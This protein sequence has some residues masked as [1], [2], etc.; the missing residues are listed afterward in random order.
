MDSPFFQLGDQNNGDVKLQ[1]ICFDGH[2]YGGN[3]IYLHSQVLKKSSYF[4][5]RLSERWSPESSF[6]AEIIITLPPDGS[7]ENYIDC[8]RL[9]YSSHW[10]K[11][12]SFSNVDDALRILPVAS[13]FLFE[14]GI[15]ACMDYLEAVCWTPEQKLRIRA[16]LSSLQVNISTDLAERLKISK[17]FFDEELELLKKIVPQ[18]LS[19]VLNKPF[20]SYGVPLK[21]MRETV[22]KQIVAYFEEDIHPSIQ[23]ICRVALL[24]EFRTRIKKIKRGPSTEIR[25]DACESLL[26][27]LDLIKLCKNGIFEAA[28]TIF[29]KDEDIAG[30]LAKPKISWSPNTAAVSRPFQYGASFININN[31]Q[32]FSDSDRSYSR[33]VLEI[34]VHRFLDALA[35]GDIIIPKRE[36]VSFLIKWVPVIAHLVCRLACVYKACEL[37]YCTSSVSL[38]VPFSSHIPG[39]KFSERFEGGVTNILASLPPSDQKQIFSSFTDSAKKFQTWERGIF[40]WWI[41]VIRIAVMAENGSHLQME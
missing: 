10:E 20:V 13:E 16:L 36:R 38:S 28:F 35:N 37:I 1:I 30:I 18:M 11:H 29:V 39:L 40:H 12:L 25:D 2:P 32:N 3:P 41:K 5:A 31:D 27:L 21:H 19:E 26:W 14:E 22:E 7:A 34:L 17:S 8:I 9:M 15:R 24:D 4:E 23:K 6:S 33:R